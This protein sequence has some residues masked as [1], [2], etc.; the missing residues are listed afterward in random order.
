MRL[1]IQL[2]L[3]FIT[4]NSCAQDYGQLTLID[5]LPRKME[6]VSGIQKMR[7]KGLI[8]MINDSGNKDRIYGVNKK[9]N[10]KEEIK[11][12][13]SKNVDWEE[14]TKDD[15]GNLYIGDFGNNRN[16]RTDLTIYKI[17]KPD[18]IKEGETKASKITFYYPEQI[19]FP[20]KKTEM[21]YDLEAFIF[22][23]DHFY[24]FTK[25]HSAEF[26]GTTLLYKIPAKKG[27]HE[28]QLIT[29]YKTCDD[30]EHCKI[31]AA[32]ISPDKS[33]IVLLGHD[34]IWVLTDFKGDN[35]YSGNVET[36]LL[37]HSSQKEGICFVDDSTLFITDE[38]ESHTNAG[39]NLYSFTL[40]N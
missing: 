26:D 10:I 40:K 33:K 35:L 1:I 6:E 34:R 2:F 8:W 21:F 29:T 12:K 22:L 4:I 30:A 13:R 11:V 5:K 16:E 25:N 17:S 23:N 28:A 37:G 27:K 9:G 14:L 31:T 38:D 32:D 20:P 15:K 7:P 24:L 18:K 3:L 36:I 19:A 39:R